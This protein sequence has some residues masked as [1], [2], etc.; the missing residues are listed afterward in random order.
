VHGKLRDLATLSLG[1]QQL[2]DL[3]EEL[4]WSDSLQE[5]ETGDEFPRKRFVQ[6]QPAVLGFRPFEDLER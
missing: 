3:S 2:E 5:Q 4:P 6:L 1:S